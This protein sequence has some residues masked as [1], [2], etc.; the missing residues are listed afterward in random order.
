MLLSL[1]GQVAYTGSIKVDGVEVSGV[2]PRTMLSN[3]T[4]VPRTSVIF[5][6]TVRQN[7]LPHEILTP[8]NE[9]EHL[10]ALEYI[11]RSL[12]LWG[13]ITTQGGLSQQMS[14]MRMT[15]NQ[16]QRFAL[17]QALMAFH[18]KKANLV[19]MNDTTSDVNT[20]SLL[21]MKAIMRDLLRQASIITSTK[22][23]YATQGS[24]M[25][26][27]VRDGGAAIKAYSPR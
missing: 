17:A 19:V 7:L 27:H 6:G 9:T 3:V 11:L 14:D 23:L 24:T 15:P 4:V 2:S 25:K 22:S 21:L 12:S 5:P 1:L 8:G 18:L 20:D 16:L 13:V 26:V 10:A